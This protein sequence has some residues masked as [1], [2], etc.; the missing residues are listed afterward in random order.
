[1]ITKEKSI[2]VT[3]G[4]SRIGRLL[5]RRLSA[6]DYFVKVLTRRKRDRLGAVKNVKLIKG[7]IRNRD[8]LKTAMEGCNYVFHIAEYRNIRDPR[9][10]IFTEVNV[11]ATGMLIEAAK[12]ARVKKFVYVSTA[13][14]FQ[15]TDGAERSEEWPKKAAFRHNHYLQTKLDALNMV[16]GSRAQLPIVV[17]YPT[18]ILDLK[19]FLSRAEVRNNSLHRIIWDKI[20]GSIPGG[21]AC[22]VGDRGRTFNYVSV[23]DLVDG[24]MLALRYGRQGEEYILGGVNTTAQGYLEAASRKIDKFIF[25]FRIPVP[26]V[27]SLAFLGWILPMPFMIYYLAK[28]PPHDLCLSSEKARRELKYDPKVTLIQDR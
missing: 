1:M 17:V 27:K 24:L 4:T 8:T 7:D 12:R 23:D 21:L 26:L 25:D 28:N 9:K 6:A 16:L 14:I 3:G 20:G 18:S 10:G 11:N 5:V 22:L 19:D 13:D 2:L 15:P